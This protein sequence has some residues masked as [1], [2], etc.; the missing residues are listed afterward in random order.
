MRFCFAVGLVALLTMPASANFYTYAEWE[1]LSPF[2]RGIYVASAYDFYVSASH[3]GHYV[4][5]AK[6]FGGCLER[7]K[8][9]N[10]QIG[11]G[12]VAFVASR[13]A[14]QSQFVSS[15]MLQYFGE[16]C[17]VAPSDPPSK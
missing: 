16:L 11:D 8:M 7:Q 5:A 13:P 14:L 12:I 9:T 2:E 15:V 1:T 4:A 3:V 17:G 10:Q 6:H